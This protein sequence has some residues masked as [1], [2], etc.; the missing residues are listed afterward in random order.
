MPQKGIVKRFIPVLSMTILLAAVLVAPVSAE[1]YGPELF[2]EIRQLIEER[3]VE[4]VDDEHLYE[5]AIEGML[6]Q[7]DPYSKYYTEEEY[8]DFAHYLDSAFSGVGIRLLEKDGRFLVADVIPGSPAS[9][10]GIQIGDFIKAVD[11]VDVAGYNMEKVVDLIQGEEGTRVR[12][13]VNRENVG[14]LEFEIVRERVELPSVEIQLLEGN[15]GYIKLDNFSD[16]AVEE[17]RSSLSHFEREGVSGLILDLRDNAGGYI[18]PAVDIAGYFADSPVAHLAG[19]DGEK[20]PVKS[21]D[22]QKWD[23]PLVVLVDYHTASAA[24]LL[25]GA[26]QDYGKG[27]LVGSHTYGK[28]KVQNVI[29]LKEGGYLVLSTKK[30]YTPRERDINW[31]GLEPDY[32][33]E[34]KERQLARA[35]AVLWQELYPEGRVFVLNSSQTYSGGTAEETRAAPLRKNG[36]IYLPLRPLLDMFDIEPEWN[37]EKRE[38]SF[39]CG[40]REISLRIGDIR[41]NIGERTYYF[42]ALPF[43]ENG[44]T[45]VPLGFLNI[46]GKDFTLSG[47]GQVIIVKEDK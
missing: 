5:G 11:G 31:T 4:E 47:E 43:I 25:A 1:G 19:R 42:T 18:W 41:Y 8:Q 14:E 22:F 46:W 6:W 17:I 20:E 39:V 44:S 32:S 36:Q 15:T 29:K 23:K 40:E 26:I 45:M 21:P 3:Y 37:P 9:E 2:E 33:V 27:A 13:T 24:E 35:Q 7:L 10:S 28:A 34:G 16:G 30:F 38:V 12:L